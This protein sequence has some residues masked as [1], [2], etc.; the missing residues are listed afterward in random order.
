MVHK[1]VE[2]EIGT[3]Q[4]S[5]EVQLSKEALFTNEGISDAGR[6]TLTGISKQMTTLPYA[7]QVQV[8][9]SGDVRRASQV[10]QFLFARGG[11]DPR[12]L[13]IAVRSGAIGTGDTVRLVFQRL[14]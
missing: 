10:Y 12:R 4:D 7:I 3:L 2:E 14:P 13:S 9:D 6:A 11:I 5:Y 1:N 8:N